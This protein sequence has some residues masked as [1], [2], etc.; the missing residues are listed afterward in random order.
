MRYVTFD[1]PGGLEVLKLAEGPRP[2]PARRELLVRVH[3]SAVNRADTLQRAGVYVP[4]SDQSQVLGAEIAGE[5]IS[6]GSY[7]T[8]FSKGDRVMGLVNGGGYADYCLMHERMALPIPDALT[9]SD[10]AALPEACYVAN[11]TLF[12]LGGLKRDQMVMI[13]AAASGMGSMA[14]QMANYSGACTMFTAGTEAKLRECLL[15]G[16]RMGILY[17][18]EDF[19]SRVD[20]ITSNGL[21]LVIDFVGAPYFDRNVEILKPGGTLILVGVLAGWQGEVNL[22]P[23]IMKRIQIKGFSMRGQTIE[24]KAAIAARFRSAWF[25]PI[26]QHR[27]RPI[28]HASYP[29]ANVADA[30]REIEANLN[31]GKILLT[32]T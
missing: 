1:K 15:H 16:G 30:H 20:Q 31:F 3:V 28:I 24:N 12:T 5:V 6:K 23:L 19:V 29:L 25:D 9:Y 11:E 4:P 8:K 7:V 22:L 26:Q 10:A 14:L 27:I 18:T 2:V 32:C 21:D 17:K 13:H